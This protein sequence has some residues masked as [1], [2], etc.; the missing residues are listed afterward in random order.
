MKIQGSTAAG[1]YQFLNS[2]WNG[3]ARQY[4]F[5]NFSP[6]NQ[7]VGA[8]ALLDQLGAL[9]DVL[10]GDYNAAIPKIKNT[11]VAFQKGGDHS[12]GGPLS[13]A[14]S[15]GSAMDAQVPEFDPNSFFNNPGVSLLKMITPQGTPGVALAQSQ[16]D[17]NLF[18]KFQAYDEELRGKLMALSLK[19]DEAES[20]LRASLFSSQP[21]VYDQQLLA[22]LSKV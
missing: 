4:G 14:P 18:S 15:L 12:G 13:S 19:I 6:Q 2:T 1:R 16:E 21:S 9:D 20:I 3:L 11:W 8:L 10:K 7:D 17:M 5:E 22:L